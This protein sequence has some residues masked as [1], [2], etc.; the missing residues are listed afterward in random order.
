MSAGRHAGQAMV[1]M[2]I[3]A[4]LFL[5]VA[6]FSVQLGLS[7]L[8]QE[9]AQSAALLAA[10]TASQAPSAGSNPALRLVEGDDAALQSLRQ[11]TL[12]MAE[13]KGC[14]VCLAS[15]KCVD[16]GSRAMTGGS[17]TCGSVALGGN[18]ASGY[19]LTRTELDGT[20]NPDCRLSGCFGAGVG[21]QACAGPPS[22]GR[23]TVCLAYVNWPP[24]AVDVWIRGA[25]R[26]LLPL[27]T[28]LLSSLPIDV[29]LRLP[30]ERFSL[31]RGVRGRRW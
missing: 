17:V 3:G 29:R 24:T 12:G 20:A 26:S 1:E 25:L 5:L 30:V 10:R 28:G 23:L 2:A 13:A 9:G 16:Y 21:M 15:S 19:G 18:L 27:P 22:T 7:V 4:A 8:A 14:T 11:S 31:G 6:L